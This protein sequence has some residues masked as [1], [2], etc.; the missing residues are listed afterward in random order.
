MPLCSICAHPQRD[1][2]D[3]AIVGGGSERGIAKRFGVSSAAVHRHKRNHLAPSLIETHNAEVTARNEGLLGQMADLTRRTLSLLAAAEEAGDIRGA[4]AAVESARK[5][6][7][8]NARLLTAA[9]ASAPA[10]T[11]A[12]P[13]DLSALDDADLYAFGFLVAKAQGQKFPEPDRFHQEDRRI[14]DFLQGSGAEG[15]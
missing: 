2:I 13:I 8:M 12:E 14:L 4:L 11:P 15:D 7:E 9:Q 1:E 10:P 3:R 5:N 6:V